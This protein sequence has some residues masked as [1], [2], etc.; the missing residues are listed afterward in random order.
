MQRNI[1]RLLIFGLGVTTCQADTIQFAGGTTT[2]T[3]ESSIVDALT[4][5]GIG[6]SPVGTGQLAGL[7]ATFPITGGSL[8]TV[9]LDTTVEHNGSGLSLFTGGTILDLTNFLITANLGTSTGLVVGDA[10]LNGSPLGSVPLFTIGNGLALS[11]TP[12]ASAAL[13][14]VFG[15]PD[16]S[17][18]LFGTAD[19]DPQAVPEPPTFGLLATVLIGATCLKH[20]KKLS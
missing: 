3:I 4:N 19:V 7:T 17:G 9:T 12:E 18:V 15:L 8:D 13:T 14:S 10:S 11:F 6:V 20:A 1:L 2:V 5:A 16:L